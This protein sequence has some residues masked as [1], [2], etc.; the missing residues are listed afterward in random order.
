MDEILRGGRHLRTLVDELLD[1]AQ[2]GMRTFRLSLEP[3]E[4]EPLL[5]E[6]VERAA[7]AALQRSV[8]VSPP[9]G[10]SGLRALADPARLAEVAHHLLAN[11]VGYNRPGGS[12]AVHCREGV[13]GRVAFDVVDTGP[14]V[15][16]EDVPRMFVPFDRLD[17]AAAGVE[18]SGLGLPLC[19]GLVEA[20]GGTIAVTSEPGRGTVVSVELPAA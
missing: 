5:A 1:V 19:K 8:S 12:V 9:G 20:M 18:G 2:L 4:L 3:V 7:A 14:G 13:G 17:A 16:P 11:A 15:R 10:A 6:A